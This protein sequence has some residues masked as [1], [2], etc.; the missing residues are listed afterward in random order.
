MKSAAKVIVLL[1]CLFVVSVAE[2]GVARPASWNYTLMGIGGAAMVFGLSGLLATSVACAPALAASVLITGAAA[3]GV[4]AVDEIQEAVSDKP[5]ESS[6]MSDMEAAGWKEANELIQ[7][8]ADKDER[9][10]LRVEDEKR[11][12]ERFK[13]GV[14]DIGRNIRSVVRNLF[15]SKPANAG[16]LEPLQP[17]EQFIAENTGGRRKKE[18]RNTDS[19]RKQGQEQK[20]NPAN[21]MKGRNGKPD[22]DGSTCMCSDPDPSITLPPDG[23]PGWAMCNKC[24]KL[25]GV[26]LVRDGNVSVG[27]KNSA[28]NKVIEEMVKEAISARRR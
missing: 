13:E 12:K 19:S 11:V 18:R 10:R 6:F 25:I 16:A 28:A 1:T 23:I 2:A 3:V 15:G 8:G 17:I 22:L 21:R 4:G 5:V 26:V 24:T 9:N 14:K 27:G 7:N 20:P